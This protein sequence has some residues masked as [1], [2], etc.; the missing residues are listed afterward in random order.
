[1]MDDRRDRALGAILG[2]LVGDALGCGCH[3]Y[4]DLEAFHRDYGPWVDNYVEPRPGRYHAGLPKGALSQ[5]GQVTALLLDSLAALGR[6]DA[7]DFGERLDGL[8][9]TLDGTPKSGRYTDKAMRDVWRNRRDGRPWGEAG[10]LAETAEAAIR[11]TVLAAALADRPSELARIALAN[12]RLTHAD[13]FIAVQALAFCLTVASLIQGGDLATASRNAKSWIEDLDAAAPAIDCFLQPGGVQRAAE[14]LAPQ[15]Q[16]PTAVALVYGMP[17]QQGM[18]LPAAYW[19]ATQFASDFETA[20][21]TAVNSGGNNMARAAL[22]GALVGARTGRRG[23][24]KRFLAGLEDSARLQATA[25]RV[26]G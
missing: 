12:I 10:S 4:Y 5:T 25:E 8:L 24:P 22:T 23:I 14:T 2:V 19:W 13:P 6:Y 26:V 11:S 18:L 9:A 21:L 1:M 17:C 7:D 20:V 15:I 3:W 16:P